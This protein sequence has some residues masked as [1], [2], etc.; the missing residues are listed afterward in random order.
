MEGYFF[1]TGLVL[2]LIGASLGDSES[3]IPCAVVMIL[4]ALVMVSGK[5]IVGR[6][7][8]RL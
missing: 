2:I 6:K 4:G 3:L 8:K 7:G 1:S 5:I